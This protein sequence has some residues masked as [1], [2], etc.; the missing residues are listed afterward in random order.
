MVIVLKVNP[1]G[2]GFCASRKFRYLDVF[3]NF[4]SFIRLYE[5]EENFPE[6]LKKMFESVLDQCYWS[7]QRPMGLNY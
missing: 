4:E 5:I 7:L 3:K 6:T 2:F 1:A